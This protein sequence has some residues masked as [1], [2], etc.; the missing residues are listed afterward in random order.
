MA[1]LRVGGERIV[2]A[3][4][5][6]GDDA[7][8]VS[9]RG[10][11]VATDPPLA[12]AELTNAAALVGKVALARRGGCPFAQKAE[13]AAAAGAVALLV[14]DSEEAAT[15]FTPGGTEDSLILVLGV[16]LGARDA[17]RG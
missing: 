12:N 14:S 16:P 10:A 5:S 2:C 1:S 8:A 9:Y 3:L 13:R 17:G 7:P 6:R 15:P 11:V 4:G